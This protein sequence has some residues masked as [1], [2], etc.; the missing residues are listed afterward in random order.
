M[1]KKSKNGTAF[2]GVFDVIM[3]ERIKFE[4]WIFFTGCFQNN[5]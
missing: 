1:V 4:S 3:E 2:F 5:I